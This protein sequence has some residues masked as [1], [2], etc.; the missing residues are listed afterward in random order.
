[1]LALRR[2]DRII[3]P[4]PD[5]QEAYSRDVRLLLLF[6]K[7]LQLLIVQFGVPSTLIEKNPPN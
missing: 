2:E 3:G 1:M 4:K 6:G 7:D 5:G